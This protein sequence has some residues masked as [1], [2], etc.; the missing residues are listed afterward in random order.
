LGIKFYLLPIDVL[1][2]RRGG[3]LA[4]PALVELGMVY[5]ISFELAL[6]V[7]IGIT[8]LFIGRLVATKL[9]VAII[10]GF[11][12]MWAPF[13]DKTGALTPLSVDLFLRLD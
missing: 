1:I 13:L 12:F 8:L 6:D 5:I 10:L 4:R 3:L 11:R 7:L 2:C 9:A